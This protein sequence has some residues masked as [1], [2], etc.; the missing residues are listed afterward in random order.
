MGKEQW[1]EED[2]SSTIETSPP[3]K[4][5][6]F[7]EHHPDQQTNNVNC[8]DNANSVVIS[9]TMHGCHFQFDKTDIELTSVVSLLDILVICLNYF[10]VS[11][12][13]DQSG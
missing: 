8:I 12:C 9:I 7:N 4:Q 10:N 11:L 2:Q 1:C 3:F 5:L 13:I 6:I